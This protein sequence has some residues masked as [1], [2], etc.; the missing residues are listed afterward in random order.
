MEISP[1]NLDY[2]HDR[3]CYFE[4]RTQR[5]GTQ[6]DSRGMHPVEDKELMIRLRRELRLSEQDE[7]YIIEIKSIG[8]NM[9]LHPSDKDFNQW[10]KQAGWI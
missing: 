3:I 8:A 4:G 2:L 7:D 6:F 9:D 1:Q 5:Y 10:R